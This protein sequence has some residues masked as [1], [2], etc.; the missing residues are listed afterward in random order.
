MAAATIGPA[1]ERIDLSSYFMVVLP[2]KR[3]VRQ[4]TVVQALLVLQPRIPR[5]VLSGVVGIEIDEAPLNLPVANLEHVAPAPGAVLRRTGAP[6]PV[7][8]LTLTGAF[9]HHEVAAREDEVEVREVMFDRLDGAADVAEHLPDLFLAV[10]NTP[11]RKIDLRVLGEQ[12]QDAAPVPGL[13][14]P[15]EGL[16]IIDYDR[17]PLLVGHRLLCYCHSSPP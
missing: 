13:S 5:R 15:V 17:L 6:R 4:V 2:W 8:M 1:Q 7:A 12:I 9:A 14:R 11:F 10:G 16:E 3:S